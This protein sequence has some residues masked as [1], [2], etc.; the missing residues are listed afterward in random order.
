MMQFY[1]FR[2]FGTLVSDTFNFFKIYGRNYFKNYFLLNGIPLIIM[3]LIFVI[4]YREF[5]SQLM[6]MQSEGNAYYFER[7]FQE[8]LWLLVGTVGLLFVLGIAVSVINYAF[9]VFYLNRIAKFQIAELKADEILSDLRHNARKLI[10]L[11]IG[12]LFVMTP[13]FMV[14]FGFSIVLIMVII[15][16]FLLFMLI[17]A[18]VNVVNFLFYDYLLTK[19][20]FFE[21][22]SFSFRSQFS[23][24]VGNHPS[25]FWKYWGT[26]T[27][28]Y[29]I[30]Y[31]IS[32]IFTMVPYIIFFGALYTVPS[33]SANFEQNPMDGTMGIIFFMIYG[34]SI[35]AS[36]IMMNFLTVACG[37]MYFDNR[38][39]L[40][41]KVHLDE[42]D[43]IGKNEA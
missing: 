4:G 3:V 29:L 32:M 9:P 1:K 25:P 24:P 19:K 35:L 11:I 18:F 5:F 39:D 40:H 2:D 38:T 21:A 37:L 41:Q 12:L 42:I 26:T 28:I 15:G 20:T 23:Y 33:E 13:I 6:G 34:I 27:V 31:V 30:M 17:P 8:N 14:I 36:F 10:K 43:T 22:F 7:Y 16:I